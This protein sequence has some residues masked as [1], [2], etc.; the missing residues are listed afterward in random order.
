MD[1]R[2]PTYKGKLIFIHST[3]ADEFWSALLEKA[4]AKLV[5]NFIPRH[6]VE[7][8]ATVGSSQPVKDSS[9]ENLLA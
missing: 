3:D 9:I 1:D 7:N 4:Y 6:V 2:L 5:F 8:E